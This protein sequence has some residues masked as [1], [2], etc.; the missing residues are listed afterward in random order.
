[1]IKP[2]QRIPMSEKTDDWKKENILFFYNNCLS[3]NYT[4]QEIA[5]LFKVA[6]G[7]QDLSEYSYIT[8]ALG[9]GQTRPELSGSPARV[10]NMD[11]I[12]PVL[13]LLL[14][15]KTKRPN[16]RI[17]FAKNSDYPSQ[18]QEE[19]KRLYETNLHTMFINDLIK[20]GVYIPGMVDENGQPIQ[21]PQSKEEIDLKVNSLPDW[22]SIMAQEALDYITHYNELDRNFRKGFY[23]WLVTVS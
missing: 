5:R 16:I 6:N 13:M 17:A 23:D 14:G 19:F 2:R 11:I 3:Q 8:D 22:Q 21:E 12:S 9:V 20:Q 1:M 4:P 7:Y 15:E 18:K 10:K